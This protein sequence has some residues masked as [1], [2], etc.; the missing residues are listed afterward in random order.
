M[1]GTYR[2]LGRATLPRAACLAA[3]LY[4]AGAAAADPP[5]RYDL[6]VGE[7]LVYER[8]VRVL[9]LD[10]DSVVQRYSQQLQ[11]WCLAS[12]LKEDYFLAELI[13]VTDQHAE[14]ARGALFHLDHRG[15]RRFPDEI[16]ARLRGLDPL[17]ELLPL[18]PA[19]L[20]SDSSWL[21]EPDH[22]GRCWRCTRAPPTDD[23]PIRI[24]FVLEDPTGVSETCAVEQRGAYWF[25]AQAGIVTRI[26]A[27]WTDRHAQRRTLAVTRLH[28]RLKQDELWCHRRIT[29]AD[30]FLRTL[31]LEDRLLAQVTAG[32]T[33]VERILAHADRLWLELVTEL[34]DRP[35]SPLR[36]LAR[37]HRMLLT[38]E[39]GRYRER[40]ALA[41]EW[42]G[43]AAAHWSLQTS[44]GRTVRSEG[45]RD[46]YVL[47][48]FWSADSLWSLRSFETLR[49][50]QKAVPA[51][52]VRVV[53]LNIDADVA[54][55]RRAAQLCGTE[56]THV[57]AGPPVGGQPP[58]ELPVFRLLDRNSRVLAVYF[59]WQPG[60]AE[61]ISALTR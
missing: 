4:A 23:G 28:N 43:A 36:R 10:G 25:D 5:L 59:G 1:S 30:K 14:P 26:E 2:R 42:L 47:E 54:A 33:S 35:E 60:L 13:H 6:G 61:K 29:E 58:R 50:L 32:P 57:L 55:G 48:Y 53:C 49:Q 22:F 51:E 46:R 40:A 52:D 3:V 7:R 16:L 27:E 38:K 20:D 17:F 41:R 18:L 37:A 11:L 39:T 45:M 24:D 19:P 9:P 44:D 8:R 56:L 31:R 21:T 34:P 12:D 15:R